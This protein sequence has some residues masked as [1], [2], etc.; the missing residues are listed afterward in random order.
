[1]DVAAVKQ[2]RRMGLKGI[3]G[4]LSLSKGFEVGCFDEMSEGEAE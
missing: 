3:D 2:G 1:M 4:C